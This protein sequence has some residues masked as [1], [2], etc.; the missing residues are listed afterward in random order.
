MTRTDGRDLAAVFAGGF[1]G[2]VLRA[3]LVAADP[4]RAKE[5]A[6]EI[7]RTARAAL[8]EPLDAVRPPL[9]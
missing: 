7:E 5:E 3:Q 2:A 6:A 1:A 8:G 4:A 9:R